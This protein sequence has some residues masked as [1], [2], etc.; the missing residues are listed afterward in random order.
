MLEVLPQRTLRTTMLRLLML[1]LGLFGFAWDSFAWVGQC[2]EERY[3]YP[4]EN[5]IKSRKKVTGKSAGKCLFL[6]LLLEN[7]Y[8]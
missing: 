2:Y 6:L 3:V 7:I 8:I 5:V 1:R 4:R